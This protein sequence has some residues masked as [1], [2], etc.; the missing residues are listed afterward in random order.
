MKTIEAFKRAFQKKFGSAQKNYEIRRAKVTEALDELATAVGKL[1]STNHVEAGTYRTALVRLRGRALDADKQAK[2]DAE[3]AFG[4]LDPIKQDAR[5]QALAATE[6]ADESEAAARKRAKKTAMDVTLEDGG[7]A[8]VYPS[9][10]PGFDGLDDDAKQKMLETVAKKISNGK[11]ILQ[12][13]LDKDPK[14]LKD[15]SPKDVS[16]F[17]WLLKS[18][19]QETVGEP[20][21]RGA[22]SIPDKGNKIRAYLDRCPEVYGRDSSH[23]LEQQGRPGQQARGMDFY[24]GVDEETGQVADPDLLLPSGMRALLVQQLTM[25]GGKSE[26][27]ERLYIKMETESARYNPLFTATD[28]TLPPSRP[29]RDGDKKN[30]VLHLGNLLKSNLGIS[31]GEDPDLKKFKEEGVKDVTKK[32]KATLDY[33]KKKNPEAYRVLSPGLSPSKL[34]VKSSVRVNEMLAGIDRLAGMKSIEL[35]AEAMKLIAAA[36][37]ALAKSYDLSGED[38]PVRAGGEVALFMGDLTGSK[39][40]DVPEKEILGRIEEEIAALEE[41]EEIDDLDPLRLA[42][43]GARE[44]LA[45]VRDEEAARTSKRVQSSLRLFESKISDLASRVSRIEDEEAD[46]IDNDQKEI[47][48]WMRD[49]GMTDHA[50][51]FLGILKRQIDPKQQTIEIGLLKAARRQIMLAENQAAKVLEQFALRIK[52]V[53]A[54]AHTDPLEDLKQ[55]QAQATTLITTVRRTQSLRGNKL[56]ESTARQLEQKLAPL[57]RLITSLEEAQVLV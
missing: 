39:K 47:G 9:D 8:K 52:A 25:P 7:K 15:P 44:T 54:C 51:E 22:M 21:E 35:D 23:F 17:V 40:Q 6:L 10:I 46:T 50:K 16:D 5:D 26:D 30:A 18:K 56:I 33:L 1:E 53:E 11:R 20:Y 34:F 3:S 57:G 48:R 36:F 41:C 45:D 13:I 4:A 24:E 42:L 43:T 32:L 14:D 55:V 29:L 2:F 37:D 49:N 31:Q 19:A 27:K 38:I 28:P 12:D